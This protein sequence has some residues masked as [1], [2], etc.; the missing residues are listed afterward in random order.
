MAR[1]LSKQGCFKR[2]SWIQLK[3]KVAA[4]THFNDVCALVGHKTP[5]RAEPRWGS[6]LLLKRQQ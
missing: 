4:Q 6:S 2:L 5:I 1:S 3:E